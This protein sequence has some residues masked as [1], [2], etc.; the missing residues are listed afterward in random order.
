MTGSAVALHCFNGHSK[1]SGKM[2]ISTPCRIATPQDFILKFGTRDYVRDMTSRAHLQI[3]GQIGSAGVLPKYV[4]YDTFVTFDCPYFFS[5]L[6]TGQ[7]A[8]LVH[9]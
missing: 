9:K 2:E 7:T 8:A 1:I 3:L 5:S 6:S 4:K